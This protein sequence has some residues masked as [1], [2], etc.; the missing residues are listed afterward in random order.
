[1]KDLIN[2]WVNVQRSLLQ[3]L[4]SLSTGYLVVVR[5]FND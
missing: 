3:H 1:M 5:T 2:N 4:D